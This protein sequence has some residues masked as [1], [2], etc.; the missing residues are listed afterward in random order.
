MLEICFLLK[1][2]R[3]KDRQRPFGPY[4]LQVAKITLSIGR[5]KRKKEREPGRKENPFAPVRIYHCAVLGTALYTLLCS[6]VLATLN[7][8]LCI[9]ERNL[10]FLG[11]P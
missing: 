7:L 5:G 4:L 8:R 2:G 10:Q 6:K 9:F 11:T 3:N 1:T